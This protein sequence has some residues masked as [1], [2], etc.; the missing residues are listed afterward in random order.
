MFSECSESVTPDT[1]GFNSISSY[2]P[3]IL[4]RVSIT[5][6][7]ESQV[8]ITQQNPGPMTLCAFRGKE[9]P[10]LLEPLPTLQT[11][12]LRHQIDDV[13]PQV[14]EPGQGPFWASE[15]LFCSDHSFSYPNLLSDGLKL[16]KATPSLP[17]V[18]SIYLRQNLGLQLH[19]SSSENRPWLTTGIASTF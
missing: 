17:T 1:W 12:K 6:H 2:Q 16:K 11:R 3:W 13:L 10:L 7:P 19:L 9:S 4:G 15:S 8:P 5:R 14:S 18:P